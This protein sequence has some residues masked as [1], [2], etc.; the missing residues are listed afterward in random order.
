M[1]SLSPLTRR[2]LSALLIVGSLTFL[3][4]IHH[5]LAP[6]LVAL[7]I[8]YILNPLVDWLALVRIRGF[9]LGRKAAVALVFAGFFAS[10]GIGALTIAPHFYAEGVRISKELPD[11]ARHFE[12][13]TLLPLLD[14]VQRTLDSYGVPINA[15]ENVQ[16]TISGLLDSGG[17]QT[18]SILKQGQAVVKGV[19][20]T[21]FSFVLV[22]M[23]TAFM[24]L[25]WPRM[26]QGVANLV[27]APYRDSVLSLGR[28]VDKG[29][30]GA[31]RGQLFV[32][33]INGVLTTLGLMVLNIKYALTI[34]L[35]AGICSLVPIFGTVI[36]TIPAVLIA[37]TQ[38]W[39]VAVEVVLLICVIHLIEA[40]ILNPKVLGHHSEVHPVLVILALVVGEHYAGAIGLLFAVPVAAIVRAVLTF[41]YRL[42]M[43]K[44]EEALPERH[45][46]LVVPNPIP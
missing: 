12:T 33:L 32:C 5:V 4:L 27:P 35:I 30:A 15:R 41:L 40:N 13:D 36:S 25:D 7:L 39:W 9:V 37:F 8:V 2:I 21:I 22:F 44:P 3:Y 46:E 24:L 16:E 19:F 10:V 11:L 34:G 28:D 43:A 17:G 31:I 6:F 14:S 45:E 20:S 29:L 38:G 23:L 1:P 42:L 26:K 18:A